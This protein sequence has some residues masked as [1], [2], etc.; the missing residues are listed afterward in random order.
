MSS[1]RR[2]LALALAA[3]ATTACMAE[4]QGP[5]PPSFPAGGLLARAQPLP[6]PEILSQLEGVYDTSARFGSGVVLHASVWGDL[7]AVPQGSLAI[8]AEAHLAFAIL[9]AG[10]L[11]ADL[12]GP[13]TD[14]LV[15]EGYW[16][17][18]EDP[19]PDPSSTGLVRAFVQPDAAAQALCQGGTVA[20]GSASLVG[21]TGLGENAPGDPLQVTWVKPRKSRLGSNGQPAFLVGAHHGGCQTSQNCGVSENTPE[22]FILAS[23]LGADYLEV[24]VRIT[25]DGVPVFFHLGLTPAVVQGVYCV[26]SIPDWTYDQLLANCRLRNGEVIPR[27]VD[28]LTY[29]LLRTNLT[30][31]LDMKTPDGIL[32]TTQLLG[33]LAQELVVCDYSTTPP[34]LP[35]G[36]APGARCLPRGSR[37]VMD[38]VYM[39]LPAPDQVT[40]YQSAQA[41]DQLAPGQ[42][43]LAEEFSSNVL[44]SP[45]CDAWSPRYTRGPMVD[46]VRQVQQAGKFAGYWTI[47]DPTAIDA[48]LTTAAP[49]GVLT[50]NL[51][52]LNQRWEAVGVLPPYPLGIP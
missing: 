47:S 16:R 27:V 4:R 2:I 1:D 45:N 22:T 40:T 48:F 50:N 36:A 10:C 25:K 17:Y 43:C 20:P 33:Q 6:R 38:R 52:L 28:M 5:K 31:W 46:Q 26:G 37:A 15:L 35:P 42:R 23:Q 32:P 9:Q 41:A 18:L 29:G 14:R 11:A 39:G 7:G 49:N 12:S 19:D 44:G 13:G 8:L 34:T 51:G 21:A 30:V 3:L 24:D